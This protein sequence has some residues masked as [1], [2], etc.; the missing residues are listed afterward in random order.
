MLLF[1]DETLMIT[2]GTGLFSNTVLNQFLS[3]DIGEIR[4]L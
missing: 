1:K 2:G 4:I 3:T